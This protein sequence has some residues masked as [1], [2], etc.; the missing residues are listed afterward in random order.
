MT[1]DQLYTQ[2]TLH[3]SYETSYLEVYNRCYSSIYS[4]LPWSSHNTM[5][6]IGQNLQ[7]KPISNL[8]A[9][10]KFAYYCSITVP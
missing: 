3:Y 6:P 10:D 2:V 1:A 7:V 4:Y 8:Q 9:S 5:N